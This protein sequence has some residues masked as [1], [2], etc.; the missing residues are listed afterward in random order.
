MDFVYKLFQ[1]N[2]NSRNGVITVVSSLGIIVNLF[3]AT[4]KIIIG[5]AVSSLAI[6]SEGINNA[7][8]AGSSF[9]T[10]VGT[11]LAGRKPT[12]EYPFGFGRI[13]YLTN[14]VIGGIIFIAGGELFKESI[15]LVFKPEDMEISYVTME[16]IFGS[17]LIKIVLSWYEIKEGERIGSASLVAVGKEGRQD[18]LGS[19]ITLASG[20]AYLIFNL[21]LDA[22]A[23]LLTSCLVL[24]LSYEVL[25]ETVGKLLGQAGDKALADKIYK[26]IREEPIIANA[27]DMILHNYGPDACSGSVNIEVDH[28]HSLGEIYKV[29]HKLQLRIMHEYHLTM[30]FGI[31]AIDNDH[32]AMKSMRVR[33]AEFIKNYEHVVAYHA[34]YIDAANQDIYIDIVVDYELRDWEKLRQDFTWFM[35]QYYPEQRLELVIETQYV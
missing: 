15:A 33:I 24:K 16:I 7:A 29:L 14:L 18:S 25:S 9:L 5:T 20:F 32:P 35:Q 1:I 22:Y 31:Y 2:K 28:K 4:M 19:L 10:L 12:Q 27:A 34:L 21:N 3:I 13:E 30:V 26:I 17:A 6:I 23:S 11:K 8:D